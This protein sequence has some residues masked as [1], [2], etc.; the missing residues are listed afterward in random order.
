MIKNYIVTP[1]VKTNRKKKLSK[2]KANRHEKS[3][4]ITCLWLDFGGE[5]KN[6]YIYMLKKNIN[7]FIMFVKFRVNS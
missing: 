1:H 7:N 2:I 4:T 5:K 6:I 3:R